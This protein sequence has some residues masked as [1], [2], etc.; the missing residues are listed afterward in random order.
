MKNNTIGPR[1]A[2]WKRIPNDGPLRLPIKAKNFAKIV[3]EACQNEPARMAI[4]ADLLRSLEQMIQLGKV[5]I[6]I[7]VIHEGVQEFERFP[8]AHFF[9][10]ERKEFLAFVLAEIIRLVTVI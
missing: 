4:A 9:A 2:D 3:N 10:I 6:G 5:C 7:A 8:Y 1:T